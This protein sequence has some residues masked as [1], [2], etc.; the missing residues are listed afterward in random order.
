MSVKKQLLDPLGT[1]CKLVALN[2]NEKNTK[3]SIRDHILIVQR[4]NGYQFLIRWCNG[5]GRENISELYYVIIRLIKWYMIIPKDQESPTNNVMIGISPE[6]KKMV[7]YVCDAFRKLQ[8]TYEFGN[9]GLALQYYINLLEQGLSGAFDENELPKYIIN[10]ELE[11]ENLLDYEKLKNF[12]DVEKI[13]RISDIYDKCFSIY[14]DSHIDDQ[15]DLIIEGYLKSVETMLQGYDK[16]FQE[17]IV[18]SNKG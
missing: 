11:S 1:L 6:F 15:K 4:P 3:I 12:W 16:S 9:G 10:K 14:N 13:R 18:N 7:K 17:L 5:D 2:F 8:E